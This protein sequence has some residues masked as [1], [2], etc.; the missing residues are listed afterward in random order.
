MEIIIKR[1]GEDEFFITEKIHRFARA[2]FIAGGF[3]GTVQGF[4]NNGG[5][6]DDNDHTCKNGQHPLYKSKFKPFR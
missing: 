3:Y 1:T 5:D 4:F 2:V 6:D